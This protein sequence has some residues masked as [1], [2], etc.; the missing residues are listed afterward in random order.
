MNCDGTLAKSAHGSGIAGESVSLEIFC[1]K[2]LYV[3]NFVAQPADPEWAVSIF[4][5]G[6]P[7]FR[8]VV[9]VPVNHYRALEVLAFARVRL[10]FLVY[11]LRKAFTV[12]AVVLSPQ[13]LSA[14]RI[15]LDIFALSQ[16]EADG[17][18]EGL[19]EAVRT[20]F[21][22]E[23]Q[24]E[25]GEALRWRQIRQGGGSAKD[26]RKRRRLI[27]RRPAWWDAVPEIGVTQ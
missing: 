11:A 7:P 15:Q 23:G 17:V 24:A 14:Y 25:D 21:Y 27:L 16:Q 18:V 10:R 4:D 3:G 20:A 8:E 26:R 6:M 1:E 9:T 2:R 13:Y 5:G 22:M 12:K 19:K